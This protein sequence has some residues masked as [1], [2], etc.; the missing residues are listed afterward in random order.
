MSAL[1]ESYLSDL[2][3]NL[4]ILINI[5]KQTDR[6]IHTHKLKRKET[7][8]AH[9]LSHLLKCILDLEHIAVHQVHGKSCFSEEVDYTNK[10]QFKI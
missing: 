6:H 2:L 8:N 10:K 7:K 1:R 5:H 9:S 3:R 4:Y